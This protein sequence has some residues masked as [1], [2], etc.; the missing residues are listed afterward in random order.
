MNIDTLLELTDMP[1]EHEVKAIRSMP[2][3]ELKF[4]DQTSRRFDRMGERARFELRRRKDLQ[5][6]R[7]MV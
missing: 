3:E 1:D 4:L 2:D 5:N 6:K 7:D